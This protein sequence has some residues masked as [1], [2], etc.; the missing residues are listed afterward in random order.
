MKFFEWNY[1]DYSQFI[2]GNPKAN[3]FSRYF[4]NNIIMFKETISNSNTNLLI[5]TNFLILNTTTTTLVETYTFTTY[6]DITTLGVINFQVSYN[7]TIDPID[8]TKTT[9]TNIYGSII[10]TGIYK[11]Y[12]KLI[13]NINFNNDNGDRIF[14]LSCY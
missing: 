4:N 12:S 2:S 1:K 8:P 6:K 13:A 5:D 7:Q 14:S 9:I 10:A 3:G 11:K